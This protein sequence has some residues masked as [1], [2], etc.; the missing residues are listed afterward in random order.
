MS[1]ILSYTNKHCSC[2]H[3]SILL[4]TEVIIVIQ[5]VFLTVLV[6]DFCLSLSVLIS[7]V[8]MQPS[9]TYCCMCILGQPRI[10]LYYM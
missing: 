3:C 1:V 7:M 10:C 4:S 2:V 9:R 5:C 8:K 6:I